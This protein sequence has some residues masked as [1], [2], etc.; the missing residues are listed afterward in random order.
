[1][2]VTMLD[3]GH[4]TS[5]AGFWRSGGEHGAAGAVSGAG[6]PDKVVVTHLGR[7]PEVIARNFSAATSPTSPPASTTA[8]CRSSPTISG[9]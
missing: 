9:S 4:F 5:P 6:L 7:D 8:A 3:G 2:K 1:M